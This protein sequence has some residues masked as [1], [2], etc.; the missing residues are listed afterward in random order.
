MLKSGQDLFSASLILGLSR[1]IPMIISTFWGQLADRLPPKPTIIVAEILATLASLG[2]LFSWQKGLDSYWFLLVFCVIKSCI[3]TFQVG[4][5]AKIAKLFSDSSYS[6]NA[7]YAIWYNKATQ[8]ATL[9]SGLAAW[10]I[11][12]HFSFET[13]V[14]FDMVTFIINGLAILLISIKEDSDAKSNDSEPFYKKFVDFYKYNPRVAVLDL[15]LCISMMGTV[16]FMARL[17]GSDTTWNALFMSGYGFAV[18]FAGV[19]ERKGY[20]KKQSKTIWLALGLSFV[21]LGFIPE[22]GWLTFAGSVFKDIFYWLL[23]HRISTYIQMDTP[24]K[25][26][27]AVTNARMVQVVTVLA[28]GELTVGAWQKILPVFYDGLWRGVF[29]FILVAVLTLPKMRY[30]A[31]NGHPQL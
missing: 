6:S 24:Q 5:R 29:C 2:I 28:L 14:L 26:M 17:G 12:E 23:F 20:L 8:G 10:L 21:T 25:N 13:A 9:F 19:I 31:K 7:K 27:G 3:A 1:F 4:S 15:C 30:E 16:S 11:I 22:M 18:W